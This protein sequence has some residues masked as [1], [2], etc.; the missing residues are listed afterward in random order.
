MPLL[1]SVSLKYLLV[2][3]ER[4]PSLVLSVKTNTLN[5]DLLHDFANVY[6]FGFSCIT[7]NILV[8]LAAS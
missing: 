7:L 1:Y 3:G 6:Y 4:D 2:F 8:V 5:T